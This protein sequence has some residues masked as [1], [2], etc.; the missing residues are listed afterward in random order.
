MGDLNLVLSSGQEQS[1]AQT[2]AFSTLYL[3][4]A[5]LASFWSGHGLAPF[6]G[7]PETGAQIIEASSP[8]AKNLGQDS[9]L[10]RFYF[11]GSGPRYG[12]A[13]E[14]SL[15]MKEMSLSH[16]EPFHFMEFRHGPK[17]MVTP[18]S[19]VYGLRST[20]NMRYEK[21][22]LEDVRALGGRTLEMGE[23]EAPVSFESGLDEAVRDILYLPVGQMLAFER[24]LSKGL[25]PDLPHNLDAVV[26]L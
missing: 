3:A 25:N 21:A 2:R 24:S 22:V 26:K 14:I 10:D 16:S 1:V 8:T 11:I 7:L 15:K 13:C 12:L 23:S 4:C 5:A 9:S 17:A 19:L 6:T 20:A 18:S